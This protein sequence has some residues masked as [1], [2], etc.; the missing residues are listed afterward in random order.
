M[1]PVPLTVKV[2]PTP[3][4]VAL[5]GEI[6]LIVGTGLFAALMVKAKFPQVPPP[7]AGLETVTCAVPAAAMSAAVMAACNWVALT[8]VVVRFEPFHRT[9]DPLTNP[10]PFT[11]KVKAA[12]P[13][14]A[15]EGEIE[16]IAGTG[17]GAVIV[18]AIL[19]QV[20][21]PGAGLK[22]VTWAVPA[23]AISAAVM[24]AC[25]CVALTNV[26]VRFAPFHWITELLMNPL[27]FTV[28]TNAAPP[29]VAL[30]GEIELIAGTGLGA[31][32]VNAALPEVPPPG[33]GLKMETWAVPADPISAAVMAACNCV[34]LT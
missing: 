32:I 17:L 8:K 13:A 14:V 33:V 16:V 24:A 7:G 34:A 27:P 28:S 23:A 15:L 21:P 18:K 9:T 26:V 10:L 30:V 6:E 2:K 22:T 20:P 29:A 31:V 11:V 25:N 5:E 4:A 3:P 12:P 1:N 19:P